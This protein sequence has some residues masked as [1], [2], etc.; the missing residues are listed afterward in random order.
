M[1]ITAQ[2]LIDTVEIQRVKARYF[3]YM[4]HRQWAEFRDLFTDDLTFFIDEARDA[5][6]T[7]PTWTSADDLVSYLASTP[8]TKVTVHQGHM[9]DIEFVDADHAEGIWAMFD[10]VDYPDRKYAFQGYGYYFESYVRCADGR[11]RISSSRLT[12]LRTNVVDSLESQPL[13]FSPVNGGTT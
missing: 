6:T 12:R 9:P 13:T 5:S 8:A 4:D 11:W 10:W 2:Q 1:M 3:R 7:T